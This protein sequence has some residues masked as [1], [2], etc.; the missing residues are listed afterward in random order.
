ILARAAYLPRPPS[1][2]A[3]VI[4]PAGSDPWPG[5]ARRVDCRPRPDTGYPCPNARRQPRGGEQATAGA[6]EG[7]AVED[8]RAE[9]RGLPHRADLNPQKIGW[10]ARLAAD[11]FPTLAL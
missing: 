10:G 1:P 7:G 11:R 3:G 4:A 8:G 5:R 2:T 6:G 9:Y